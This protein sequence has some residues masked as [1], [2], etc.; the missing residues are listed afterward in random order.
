MESKRTSAV[1][2]SKTAEEARQYNQKLLDHIDQNQRITGVYA[3]KTGDQMGT[4][5]SDCGQESRK[6]EPNTRTDP[7]ICDT[8]RRARTGKETAAPSRESDSNVFNLDRGVPP[9]DSHRHMIQCGCDVEKD[10]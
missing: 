7:E 4:I 1:T 6:G 2:E 8:H 3:L 10:E 9:S 5:A